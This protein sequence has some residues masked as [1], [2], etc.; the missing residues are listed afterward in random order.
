MAYFE[1]LRNDGFKILVCWNSPMVETIQVP[2]FHMYYT[3]FL[4]SREST[5]YTRIKQLSFAPF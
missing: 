4:P 1:T 2:N 5:V 3:S